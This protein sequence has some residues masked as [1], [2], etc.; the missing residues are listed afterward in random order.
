MNRGD[1][2]VTQPEAGPRRQRVAMRPHPIESVEPYAS[3]TIS[4]IPLSGW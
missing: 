2:L 1:N 4:V 3:E